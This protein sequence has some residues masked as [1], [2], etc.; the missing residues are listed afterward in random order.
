MRRRYRLGVAAGVVALLLLLI[1]FDTRPVMTCIARPPESCVF[2]VRLE[3]TTHRICFREL[4][5]TDFL[6]CQDGE[7]GLDVLP[8]PVAPPLPR[9]GAIV[10]EALTINP[11]RDPPLSSLPGSTLGFIPDPASSTLE[12]NL[13]LLSKRVHWRWGG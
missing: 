9:S 11:H 1:S 2:H 4:G 8:V 7:V 13:V 6:K 5:H 10:F 12:N 3:D